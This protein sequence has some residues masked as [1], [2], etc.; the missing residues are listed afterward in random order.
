MPTC[1]LNAGMHVFHALR[2]AHKNSPQT[3]YRSHIPIPLFCKTP[4]QAKEASPIQ[5]TRSTHPLVHFFS[6]YAQSTEW[7]YTPNRNKAKD[8]QHHPAHIGDSGSE[9]GR[10][11]HGCESRKLA[12]SRQ[13]LV[14]RHSPDL[15]VLKFST[16]D[17]KEHQTAAKC[18]E[19][20]QPCTMCTCTKQHIQPLLFLTPSKNHPTIHLCS[21]AAAS[22]NHLV[23][24]C[25]TAL[26][27]CT[28][29]K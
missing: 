7:I 11:L 1:W 8:L 13:Q 25:S 3:F 22:S 12:W 19:M 14:E 4:Q 9:Q 5:L 26:I 20:Q 27:D 21:S 24:S 23:K 15:G 29:K 28:K 2:A 10:T 17:G 6:D 18:G 16:R